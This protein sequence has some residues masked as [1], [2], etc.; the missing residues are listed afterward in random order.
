MT[1]AR[2]A[3]WNLKQAVAP[4]RKLPD[5]WRWLE[6]TVEPSVAVLTEAKVPQGGPPPGWSAIWKADGIDPKRRWG[7]V[8]AAHGAEIRPLQR[9]RKGLRT[10]D[11]SFSFPG[12][13]QVVDVS[14]GGEPWCTVVGVYGLGVN[15]HGERT[16]SGYWTVPLAMKELSPLFE[17]SK[18]QR[19]LLGGDFNLWPRDA[20]QAM[21]G[22]GLIDLVEHTAETRPRLD[23]CSGCSM[24]PDCGHMW[25]HRNGNSPGAAVQHIDFLYGTP[26]M[27]NELCDVAGGIRDFPAAWDVSDHAPIVADFR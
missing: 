4:K 7:T 23:G 3:T 22:T 20:R 19:L 25:T 9:V 11:L 26:E 10:Y 18:G 8:I 24:G 15:R 14:I 1:V 12:T 13:I 21:R 17:S 6:E 5:L 2:F 27:V 16:G